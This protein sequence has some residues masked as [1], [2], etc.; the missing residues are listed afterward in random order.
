MR[1]DI[2]AGV[3]PLKRDL[4]CDAWLRGGPSDGETIVKVKH[5]VLNVQGAGSRV[6]RYEHSDKVV[7]AHGQLYVVYQHAA[8]LEGDE[9]PE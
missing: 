1:T 3:G 9:V 5:R 7:E 4:W 8:V 2:L 6:H